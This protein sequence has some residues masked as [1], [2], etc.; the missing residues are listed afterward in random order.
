MGLLPIFL[1]L[2]HSLILSFF[3]FFFFSFS[4]SFFLGA[5]KHLYN[6]LC[7]LVGR[8]VCLSV[9]HSFDDPHVA[10]IGLLGLVVTIVNLDNLS[11]PHSLSLSLPFFLSLVPSSFLPFF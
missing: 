7:P 5:T 1:C 6:W 11:S 2:F 10:P 8:L 4:F 3:L 9:T